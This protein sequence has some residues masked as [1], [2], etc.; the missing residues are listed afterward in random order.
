MK[1]TL[2]DEKLKEKFTEDDKRL[3][4]DTTKDTLMWIEGHLD[5]ELETFQEKQKELE[6][7]FNPIMMKVYQGEG[8]QG[9]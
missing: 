1:N 6:A 7:K 4:E 9:G 5:A 2:N 3:I 8:G